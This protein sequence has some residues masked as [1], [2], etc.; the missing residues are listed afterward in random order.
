MFHIL[1]HIL[2]LCKKVV[3]VSASLCGTYIAGDFL[4]LLHVLLVWS[5]IRQCVS[6]SLGLV[7]LHL[8]DDLRNNH[9]HILS[10]A[11]KDIK[12]WTIIK[13]FLTRTFK[14]LDKNKTKLTS[15]IFLLRL[16]TSYSGVS[17]IE[18]NLSLARSYCS[19]YLHW[20]RAIRYKHKEVSITHN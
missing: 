15:L 20:W 16:W 19:L 18:V 8:V 4:D 3:Q 14:P 11:S 10:S 17:R 7:V 5:V 12:T 2:C 9:H 1:A 13:Q 6:L